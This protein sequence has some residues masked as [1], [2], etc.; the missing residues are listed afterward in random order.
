MGEWVDVAVVASAKDR[1]GKL[2]VR[3]TAGF[4]LALFE[5]VEVAFVPPVIDAPRRARVEALRPLSDTSANARFDAVPTADVA[6]MLVGC[7][8]LVRAKDLKAAGGEAP[9]ASVE[10]FSVFDETEGE[11]GSVSRVLESPGQPLLEV[12][13]PDGRTA[14]VPLVDEIV[15]RV[16]ED[17]RRIDVRAPR[18]LFDL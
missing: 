1:T 13:R 8:V 6:R 11:I 15:V 12:A 9:A 2:V 3:G 16:D 14:L 5:G 18:G 4:S 10:G 7:H 17:S